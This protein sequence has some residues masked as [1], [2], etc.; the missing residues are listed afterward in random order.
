MLRRR[1]IPDQTD[2]GH[3]PLC[4][5]RLQRSY[6][7]HRGKVLDKVQPPA[8]ADRQQAGAGGVLGEEYVVRSKPDGYT[9]YVGQGSGHDVVMPHLQKMPFNPLKDIT[10]VARLSIHSIVIC[11]SGKS[12]I[13]SMKDLIAYAN[14]GNKITAAVSTAAGSVDLVMRAISKRANIP[15]TTVPFAGGA[16][17]TTALAGGHLTIGGGHPSEVMPHLKAGRFKAIGVALDKRDPVIP[18]VPTLKEQGIDVA[19]WGSVKGVA[20]PNGTPPEIIEYIAS[21]LKKISEDP[22]YKKAMASIYQPIDYLNTKDWTAFL[23][24]EYKDYG[25]L[26]K[27]LDIKI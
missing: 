6:G 4:S 10:P 25:D 3:C 23:Q 8:D 2:P 16:E 1:Q 5:R 22:A 17:S 15:I 14:K 9:I 24:R 7:P 13:N 12:P 11:V 26:I 20:V 19:T 21:T 18:K 27:E